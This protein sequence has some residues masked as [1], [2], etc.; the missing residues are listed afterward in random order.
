MI[1]LLFVELETKV[2]V[3]FLLLPCLGPIM[4]AVAIVPPFIL[5]L[6]SPLSTK[7][8]KLTEVLEGIVLATD[9]GAWEGG[10]IN[11]GSSMSESSLSPSNKT[12][13]YFHSR[14]SWS[15]GNFGSRVRPILVM[16]NVSLL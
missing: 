10:R 4:P 16:N 8:D 7:D 1:T 3:V 2:S 14:S 15:R 12:L 5:A 13:M 6:D 9:D 11:R